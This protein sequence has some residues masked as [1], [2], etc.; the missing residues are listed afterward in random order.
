M[1]VSLFLS[2]YLSI[3]LYLSA[4]FRKL[5]NALKL[6]PEN[7]IVH[8]IMGESKKNL[9]NRIPYLRFGMKLLLTEE[10]L[11]MIIYKIESEYKQ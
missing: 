9:L 8:G 6:S 10:F 5:F 1:T 3:N 11:Y 7:Q 2:I 4:R